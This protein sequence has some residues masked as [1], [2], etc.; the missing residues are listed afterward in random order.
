MYFSQ[1]LWNN[2]TNLSAKSV[3]STIAIEFSSPKSELYLQQSAEQGS[4]DEGYNFSHDFS[5]SSRLLAR[6]VIRF[7]FWSMAWRSTGIYTSKFN[8][9]AD[10]WYEKKMSRFR[11]IVKF[12]F[13]KNMVE[14]IDISAIELI[15]SAFWQ[16]R[17]HNNIH[18]SAAS[19]WVY[20][21]RMP[22]VQYSI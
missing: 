14:L 1:V 20:S 10:F 13:I 7:V 4:C 22:C 18:S 15:S 11:F 21:V 16:I 6:I 19:T 17:Q 2:F 3:N 9:F 12:H 5:S 8:G